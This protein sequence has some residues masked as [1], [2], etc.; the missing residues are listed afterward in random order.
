MQTQYPRRLDAGRGRRPWDIIHPENQ[1]QAPTRGS[2]GGP[3]PAARSWRVL[4]HRTHR[5]SIQQGGRSP[6]KS[7]SRGTST[8]G[9]RP[10]PGSRR[11]PKPPSP[12]EDLEMA[13]QRKTTRCHPLHSQRGRTAPPSE[14][15]AEQRIRQTNTFNPTRWTPPEWPVTRTMLSGRMWAMTCETRGATRTLC[16]QSQ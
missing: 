2:T 16:G 3:P 4:R 12:R 15:V 13:A 9:R 11:R 14:V 7:G 8:A 6:G 1:H 10:H 5:Q